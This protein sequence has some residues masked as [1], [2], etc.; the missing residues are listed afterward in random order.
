MSTCCFTKGWVTMVAAMN[1]AA[2]AHGRTA[3]AKITRHPVVSHDAGRCR[4]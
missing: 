4:A 1:E 3:M 2:Q